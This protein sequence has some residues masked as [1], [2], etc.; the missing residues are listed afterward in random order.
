M[1]EHQVTV[2]GI[3]RALPSPF[4]LMATENPIEYEGTFPLP[5]AQLDRFFLR[6]ALGYP[7]LDDEVKILTEQR[8]GHPLENLGPVVGLDDVHT[9][10]D[11]AQ[12]I[13]VDDVLHRWIV[14]LVRSTREHES[15]VIGSSVRGSLA[16]ERAAR[17]WALLDDRSYVLPQDVERLFVPV[18]AHRVVFTP[19]FV[20]RARASGWA[21]AIEEFHQSCL[22]IAP[23]PGSEEDPL[24]DGP[25]PA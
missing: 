19:S 12:R 9:L 1:A 22:A 8:F 18:L 4:L 10:R 2:D 13:Y 16:L 17:A 20:A 15:V 7:G 23:R 24:F 25:R 5:E 21:H 11:A 14:E 3:T 6:A